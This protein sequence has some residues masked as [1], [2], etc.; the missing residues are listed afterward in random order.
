MKKLSCLILIIALLI[1]SLPS[2][3]M[4]GAEEKRGGLDL[5]N[6]PVIEV[7]NDETLEQN[8]TFTEEKI[9]SDRVFT[10]SS[11]SDVQSFKYQ[12]HYTGTYTF[13]ADPACG[14]SVYVHGGN[15]ITDYFKETPST[16]D[17]N[18]NYEYTI[19]VKISSE[20]YINTPVTLTV[21]T[22]NL[23]E[24]IITGCRSFSDTWT[25]ETEYYTFVAPRTGE[26]TFTIQNVGRMNIISGGKV[27]DYTGFD[28]WTKEIKAGGKITIEVERMHTSGEQKING[29][30]KY[31]PVTLDITELLEENSCIA[32]KY[33]PMWKDWPLTLEF[34]LSSNKSLVISNTDVGVQCVSKTGSNLNFDCLAGYGIVDCKIDGIKLENARTIV[35]KQG[36]K[37]TLLL[38]GLSDVN[39]G[40]EYYITIFASDV[41]KSYLDYKEP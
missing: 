15:I 40:K 39:D 18:A 7:G 10:F 17:L 12:A 27:I 21:S 35:A 23:S 14:L 20:A 25:G 3:G 4:F 36:E 33:T 34:T 37:R 32:L 11:L 41:I 22:P 1:T 13:T 5:T 6:V 28:S 38:S 29:S 16:Y 31:P 24:Q 9:S 8:R 26:Y 2:C 19:E 30:I